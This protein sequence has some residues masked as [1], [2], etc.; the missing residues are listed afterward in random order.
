M[1]IHTKM[2]GV[3]I[4][5]FISGTCILPV[6][7]LHYPNEIYLSEKIIKNNTNEMYQKNTMCFHENLYEDNTNEKIN[8]ITT[9]KNFDSRERNFKKEGE[10][11]STDWF[12]SLNQFTDRPILWEY[13]DNYSMPLVSICNNGSY[14]WVGQC[15]NNP[16]FQLIKTIGSG[17]PEW[18]YLIPEK[19][20]IILI[21]SSAESCILA[22]VIFI[23]FWNWTVPNSILL[24]WDISNSSPKWSF[25][26]PDDLYPGALCVSNDG[27]RL[28]LATYNQSQQIIKIFVFNSD[29]NNPFLIYSISVP[30]QYAYVQSLDISNDGSIILVTCGSG[31]F[32]IDVNAPELRWSGEQLPASISGDGSILVYN[33]Y[34][35]GNIMNLL[36]WDSNK[37][38]YD[39]KW[40]HKFT[41]DDWL[42]QL[43][44]DT[45]TISDD[46]S[47]ILVGVNYKDFLENKVVMFNANNGD[48]LW[49]HYSKGYGDLQ[50]VVYDIKLSHNGSKAIVGY[51][52]DEFHTIPVIK[53]FNRESKNPVLNIYFSGSTMS[54]DIS[55]DEKF[56][57]AGC[58]MIHANQFG[59][60]GIIYAIEVK[61]I[62]NNPPDK[63]KTPSGLISG[64]IE[65]E[66]NY[67]TNTIDIDSDKI[68]YLFDWGDGSDSGWIGPY[69]NGDI[70]QGSHVWS[71]KR[72]YDIKV[73]AKDIYGKESSWSDPLP[74]IMPYSSK[75]PMLSFLELL[76]QRSPNAFPILRQLLEF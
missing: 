10:Y 72:N 70:C 6:I 44:G 19:D 35:D 21:D 18:E 45:L 61:N 31:S 68:F 55:S 24:T 34:E 42:I 7:G 20:E 32:I 63:P 29:S 49:E 43:N 22:G 3:L 9:N 8:S 56:S 73:K 2:I 15:L 75:K 26:I 46:G 1:N 38:K 14:I 37:N 39:M 16:R 12:Q 53:I 76:F 28:V 66:Y 41:P 5:I 62:S 65:I 50:N 4:I 30:E 23:D 59:Y 27:S 71:K 74:I 52:G 40:Q 47:T 48:I 58:K 36:R 17:L 69:K 51:W 25:N 54:V 11:G 57:V 67:S 60:G 33:S 13:L 64:K